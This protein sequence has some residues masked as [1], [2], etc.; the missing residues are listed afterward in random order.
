MNPYLSPE[1]FEALQQ[2]WVRLLAE[3]GCTPVQA[4]P[5]FDQLVTAYAEPHRHYHTLEHIYEMFRVVGRL[6]AALTDPAAVRL[7]VWFHDVVYSP[8]AH[9]NANE[10]RSAEWLH[11]ALAPLGVPTATRD[12]AAA[13]ILL[14]THQHAPT[15][16]EAVALLDA[17]LAI[18]AAA[19][20]RYTRYAAAI[21]QEYAHID[22]A[23]YRA[24]R[25]AVLESFLARPQ[26]FH[27]PYLLAEGE[28]LAR[29][30]LTTE[31]D[32]LLMDR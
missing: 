11:V 4:Y 32:T 20:P 1:R 25:R 6:S 29:H 19:E 23:A 26:I 12:Q 9:G 17:D 22:E 24:G 15:T 8:Q 2:G 27:H 16:P 5:V 10:V 14:T 28:S 31:R 3:W 18:L 21:R 30:N 7:A 13:L